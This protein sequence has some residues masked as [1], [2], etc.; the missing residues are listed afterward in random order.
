MTQSKNAPKLD[1]SPDWCYFGTPSNNYNFFALDHIFIV[2]VAK[3]A[4]A[5]TKIVLITNIVYFF[6]CISF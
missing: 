5:I 4:L 1:N 2:D 6:M 3:S